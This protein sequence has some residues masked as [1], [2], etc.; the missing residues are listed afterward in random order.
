VILSTVV[1]LGTALVG[2][3]GS[4][5]H[6][7]R[8]GGVTVEAS[9]SHSTYFTSDLVALRAEQR[10]ALAVFRPSAFTAVSGLT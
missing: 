8:R 10:E 9:N 6:L 1:G 4:A 2:S 5:A 3:F 7:Y